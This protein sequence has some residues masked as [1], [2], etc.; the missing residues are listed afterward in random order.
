MLRFS[1]CTG[2]IKV[3]TLNKNFL[4]ILHGIPQKSSHFWLYEAFK[5][6]RFDWLISNEILSEYIEKLTDIYSENTANL[7][8][9]ILS[10]A[11]NVDFKE[12]FF[13]WQLV[14]LGP[15]DNKFV[16]LAIAGNADYLVTNDKHFDPLKSIEFP[17]I[18]I[19][20]MDNFKKIMLD[21][22]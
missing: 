17:K 11:P 22:S 13:R 20:S 3:Q 18:N 12:P 15:D 5:Q 8:Y 9:S 1:D 10:V 2:V 7:V 4:E 6:E 21:M 14:L 19:V 16:D